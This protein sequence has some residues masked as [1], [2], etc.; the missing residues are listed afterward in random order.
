VS[1]RFDRR[2][3]GKL[4]AE[5]LH[6]LTADT[7]V[8]SQTQDGGECCVAGRAGGYTEFSKE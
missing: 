7:E 4:K 6:A 3:Y 8:G 2:N 1:I 5:Q